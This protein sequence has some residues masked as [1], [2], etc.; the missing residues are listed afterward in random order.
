[1]H[2]SVYERFD[3]RTVQVYDELTPYRPTTL[4]KHNDFAAFYEPGAQFPAQSLQS[5]TALAEE[6]RAKYSIANLWISG[7]RTGR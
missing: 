5:A 4:T 6:P 1:M 7:G 2:R 3:L